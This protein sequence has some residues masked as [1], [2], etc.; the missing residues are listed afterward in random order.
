M[1]R[2]GSFDER[3]RATSCLPC[4]DR[5]LAPEAAAPEGPRGGYLGSIS[6]AE[7]RPRPVSTG[8]RPKAAS[9]PV[10]ARSAARS[11]EHTSELQSQFHLVCRL[12][13]EKKKASMYPCS[14]KKQNEKMS[15]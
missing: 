1:C 5:T 2:F 10:P 8:S 4:D 13:L 6:R 12:L 7:V 3:A 11:E 14:P 15:P 9:R